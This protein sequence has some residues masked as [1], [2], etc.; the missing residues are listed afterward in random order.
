MIFMTV[1]PSSNPRMAL[2][3]QL[4]P[5]FAPAVPSLL[6]RLVSMGDYLTGRGATGGGRPVPEG[7]SLPRVDS[8]IPP[9]TR[10]AGYLKS[11][12]VSILCQHHEVPDGTMCQTDLGVDGAK[13]LNRLKVWPMVTVGS[14]CA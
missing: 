14:A 3:D 1:A 13:L 10:I 2:P 7:T 12:S 11:L 6:G 8:L 9:G 5:F 4:Q